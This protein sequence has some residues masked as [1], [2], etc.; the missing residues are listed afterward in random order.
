MRRLAE[1][2]IDK[3]VRRLAAVRDSLRQPSPPHTW[4]PRSRRGSRTA[5][6]V[7]TRRSRGPARCTRPRRCTRCASR[8]RSC[9][10]PWRSPT[11][12]ARFRG[13][14]SS[15]RCARAQDTLGRLHDLQ[16][17]QH[18]VSEVGRRAAGALPTPD[19]GL[20]ILSRSIEDECR[21][22]HGR[23]VA[24]LPALLE[25]V[26]DGAPGHCR[27]A[28]GRVARR[29]ARPA[30]MTLPSGGRAASGQR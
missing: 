16:V 29:S 22:L 8:P 9:A 26:A 24:L 21:H 15:G 19:A 28:D 7:S 10:T 6:V 13:A 20:A 17:L 25:A 1:V 4:R 27:P 23:Y 3:L 30:K 2:D 11:R 12:A 14:R 18:H 5:R